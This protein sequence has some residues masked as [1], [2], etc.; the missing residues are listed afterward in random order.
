[1][2]GLGLITSAVSL[3][4]EIHAGKGVA[5]LLAALVIG[6][7]VGPLKLVLGTL[8][9]DFEVGILDLATSAG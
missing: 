8:G 2:S 1:M 7:S 3:G 6:E 5:N 4:A 9:S